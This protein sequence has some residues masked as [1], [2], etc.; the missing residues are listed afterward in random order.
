M[1]DK[2]E[3]LSQTNL[4]GI[5]IEVLG[6]YVIRGLVFYGVVFFLGR[7][8]E[9]ISVTIRNGNNVPTGR[10]HFPNAYLLICYT[11]LTVMF[12]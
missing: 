3:N 1:R 8:L 2:S 5:S 9:C 4:E 11:S 6:F 10:L 12:F 7:D